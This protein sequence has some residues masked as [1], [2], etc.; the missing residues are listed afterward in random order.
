[1]KLPMMSLV[2]AKGYITFRDLVCIFELQEIL[3][4]F[5]NVLQARTQFTFI[6]I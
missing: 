3:E 6:I 5:D 1:M 4:E 2:C